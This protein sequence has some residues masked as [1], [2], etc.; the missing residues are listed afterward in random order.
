MKDLIG[1]YLGENP[2]D[3]GDS[4]ASILRWTD[5]QLELGHTYIQW[6]FPLDVPSEIVRN[7]PVITQQQI[8][9]FLKSSFLQ[10]RMAMAFGRMSGFYGFTVVDGEDG[11]C[12]IVKADD[13]DLKS[14]YWI[15]PNNHNYKRLTRIMTSM[16]MLGHRELAKALQDF[17]AKLFENYPS[18]IGLITY[19]YWIDAV[20]EQGEEN[21]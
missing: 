6:L 11:K 12:Q 3:S 13:F 8:D 16:N 15:S 9:E 18:K 5:A 20:P 10:S 21:V 7:S 1:F 14:R 4:F 17:L 19:T 2:N